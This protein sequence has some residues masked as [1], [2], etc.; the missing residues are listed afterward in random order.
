[1][2]GRRDRRTE[3]SLARLR[4]RLHAEADRHRPDTARMWA[5]IEAA[6]AEP[7]PEPEPGSGRDEDFAVPAPRRRLGGFR[8]AAT[9]FATA[10]VLGVTSLVVLALSDRAGDGGTVSLGGRVAS[11]PPPGTPPSATALGSGDGSASDSGVAPG[12]PRPDRGGPARP[13][14]GPGQQGA[15]ISASGRTDGGSPYWARNTVS[16]TVRRPLGAL[17]VT[18]R[19]GRDLT[20]VPMGGWTSLPG[21]YSWIDPDLAGNVIVH[22]FTLYR[23]RRVEPGTYTFAVQYRPGSRRPASL[24]AF[25]VRATATE[26]GANTTVNGRF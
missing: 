17:D 13:P 2:P 4:E 10:T 11:S 5:R 18:I 22:R 7:E 6:L 3:E 9:G 25:T 20:T 21:T 1:M 19:V 8:V 15:L 26:G 24:D 16:L 12:T 23:G 14:A